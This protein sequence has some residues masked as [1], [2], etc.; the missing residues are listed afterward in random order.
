[1]HTQTFTSHRFR[2]SADW[3][4]QIDDFVEI[5]NSRNVVRGGVVE[6]VMPDGS[7]LWLEA[8][9]T[10]HRAYFHKETGLELWVQQ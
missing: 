8:N 7:G 6:A 10:D 3:Q 2:L 4:C 5:R 1:M 9:G